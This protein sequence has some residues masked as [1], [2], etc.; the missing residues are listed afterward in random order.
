MFREIGKFTVEGMVVGLDKY[1]YMAE[2]SAS[3]LASSVLDNV[4]NPLKNVS[5]ILDGEINTS[6]KITPVLD[7]TNVSEGSKLLSNMLADQDMQINART[8]SIAGSVGKIQNRYD[9]SDVISAL[10]G[11]KE[12]LNNTG[13]SYTINGI[14]YDDGSNVSAA[15]QTL[16]RA[17][18]IERR[19]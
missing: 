8:S 4:R 11:L 2:E 12:S 7:L 14:T 15:V 6:P 17:A 1:A 16:V 13:P 5:K 9:N 3:G 19:L 10:N 18:R